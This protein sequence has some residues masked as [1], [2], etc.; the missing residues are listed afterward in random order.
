MASGG[1]VGRERIDP[2]L[3]EDERDEAGNMSTSQ[4]RSPEAF[5][6]LHILA[7]IFHL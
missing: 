3:T 5:L 7:R 6:A 2:E 1:P 4:S